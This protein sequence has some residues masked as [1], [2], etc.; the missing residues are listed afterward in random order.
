MAAFSASSALVLSFPSLALA[1]GAAANGF[2]EV[3]TVTA[4]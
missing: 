2:V 1:I 4:G 3:S